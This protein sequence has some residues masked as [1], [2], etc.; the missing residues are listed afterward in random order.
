MSKKAILITSLI[1]LA[2]LT[3][4]IPHWPNFTALGAV[5]LFAGAQYRN[6]WW[7]YLMPLIALFASDLLLNNL[8]YAEYQQGFSWFTEGFLYI[9][10]GVI[11]SVLIGQLNLRKK[12][13]MRIAGSG[14]LS[15]V[16]FFIIT[17]FGVWQG[18]FMYPMNAGGLLMAY[19][20]GLPFLVYQVAGTLFYSA[21]LFGLAWYLL[22]QHKYRLQ[23][24]KV[25]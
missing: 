22:P 6:S 8:I 23:G 16:V 20:A 13:A 24:I 18:G 4:L 1:F 12:S 25:D 21:I 11:F 9:Y 17:N 10:L 15:S 2:M 14:L 3:R 7:A 5:A 19:E